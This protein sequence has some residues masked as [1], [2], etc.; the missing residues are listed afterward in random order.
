MQ[1][2]TTDLQFTRLTL[3]HW[4]IGANSGIKFAIFKFHI[5]L[6]LFLLEFFYWIL[7]TAKLVIKMKHHLNLLTNWIILV[8]FLNFYTWTVALGFCR[9]DCMREL[10]PTARTN[11]WMNIVIVIPKSFSK[12]IF[13]NIFFPHGDPVVAMSSLL[14][15]FAKRNHSPCLS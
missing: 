12:P 3:Y 6:L 13:V 10:Q 7:Q 5:L 11:K 9:F 1:D 2:R 14:S 4:A 8:F 15:P